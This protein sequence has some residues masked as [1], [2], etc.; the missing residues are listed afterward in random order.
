MAH[1]DVTLDIQRR[2]AG[3]AERLH[4]RVHLRLEHARLRPRAAEAGD[5]LVVYWAAGIK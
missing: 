1:P 5:Q 4:V 3:E 2:R